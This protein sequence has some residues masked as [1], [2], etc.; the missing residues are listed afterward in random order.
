MKLYTFYKEESGRW[1]INL[2]NYPGLKDDLEMVCGADVML[3]IIAQGGNRLDLGIG[4]DQE[5]EDADITL[6]LVTISESGA[7]YHMRE[8]M[9]IQFDLEMWLCDVTKFVFGDF[10]ETIYIFK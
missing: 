6:E 4:I 10:P 3:D 2:P 8:Y 7:F 5:F 9:G 1:F